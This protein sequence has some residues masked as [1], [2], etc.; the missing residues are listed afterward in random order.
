MAEKH[1]LKD[2]V[3][4]IT[5]A[6]AGIGRAI[7]CEFAREGARVMIAE[8]REDRGIEAA[9]EIADQTGAEVQ[10]CCTDVRDEGQ[11]VNC[12]EQTVE[13]FGRLDILVNNASKI[14]MCPVLEMTTEQ[15]EEIMR[16]NATGMVIFSREAARQ[17]VKQGDGGTMVFLS[18]IHAALSEPNCSAYTAAKGAIESYARTLATEMAPHRIRVNLI[19]P[20]A[21]Y[22]ELTTPMYTEPVKRSLFERVPMKE[23]AQPEWIA[24]GVVFLASDESRY[25]TGETLV[26]DGGYRMDGSLPGAAYWED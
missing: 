18:S 8:L 2:K 15:Y 24:R 4:I 1:L 20:G 7:A 14:I 5:G 6:G 25:M 21:T 22:S 13:S 17:M 12:I 16:N 11:I 23:I 10:A 19:Q 26:M 3:A 9:R